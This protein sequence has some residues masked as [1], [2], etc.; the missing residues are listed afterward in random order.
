MQDFY[1]KYRNL[2]KLYLE[3]CIKYCLEDIESLKELNNSYIEENI[4]RLDYLKKI[5]PNEYKKEVSKIKSKKFEGN[6]PAFKRLSIIYEKEKNYE[7][8]INICQQAI[9]YGQI[10]N[11]TSSGFP[12]RIEKLK[13]KLDRLENK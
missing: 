7:K 6:I 3:K 9:A 1:Y 12:G 10:N 2:D 11:G 13:S 8:A 4:K 5:N